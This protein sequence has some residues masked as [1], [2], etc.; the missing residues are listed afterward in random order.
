VS[1][2]SVALTKSVELFDRER[3]RLK[4]ILKAIKFLLGRGRSKARKSVSKKDFSACVLS[5]LQ[6]YDGIAQSVFSPY[7]LLI[8]ILVSVCMYVLNINKVSK[9]LE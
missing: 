1:I 3:A 9:L 4:N 5:R 6:A 7:L 8:Y 2:L